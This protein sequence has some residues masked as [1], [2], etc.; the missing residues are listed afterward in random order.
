MKKNEKEALKKAFNI[1]DPQHKE[2]FIHQLGIKKNSPKRHIPIITRYASMAAFMAI[3]IGIISNL[4]L[5]ADFPD[6]FTSD[7]TIIPTIPSYVTTEASPT[8][9]TASTIVDNQI[10]LQTTV[11]SDEFEIITAYPS[12]ETTAETNS[13]ESFEPPSTTISAE[14]PNTAETHTATTVQTNSPPVSRPT[15]PTSVTVPPVTI[16][17]TTVRTNLSSTTTKGEQTFPITTASPNDDTDVDT[18]P[19]T[20][21][22]KSDEPSIDIP[23]IITA[24]TTKSTTPIY[25]TTNIKP[26]SYDHEGVDLT[27]L[28]TNAYTPSDMIINKSDFDPS[29]NDPT[30]SPSTNIPSDITPETLVKNSAFIFRGVIKEKI[31]TDV[32]GQPFTQENIMITDIC[33][34]EKYYNINDLISVYS[35]GGY[36]SLNTYAEANNISCDYPDN[37]TI[38]SDGGNKSVRNVGEEYYFFLNYGTDDMPYG[39][40]RLTALTDISVFILDGDELISLGNSNFRIP[41]SMA[42]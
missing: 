33:K 21:T 25:T 38:Y 23:P 35:P 18:K 32:S 16:P 8:A 15:T 40:F 36:M 42:Y 2:E 20:T 10:P 26:P 13:A 14:P 5:T 30:D 22:T 34:S 27:V 9:T 4:S 24:T 28:P 19:V 7:K 11:S 37:Y 12:H 41:L 1:P 17:E 39:A 3:M 6:Q 31:Y 29:K